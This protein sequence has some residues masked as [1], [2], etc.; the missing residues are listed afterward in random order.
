MPGG[1][2]PQQRE[3]RINRFKREAQAAGT[4]NHPNI[5]TVYELGQEGDRLFMA[6]EYL[7]G[8]NLRNEI[9][10]KGFLPV[11]Q[12]VRIAK[13]ILKGLDFAHERGVIHRDIKPDNIQLLSNGAVKITDFGIARLTFQP[14]LT[15]DG[16]VF[17]TP[18]YMSPEQVVGREIDS[19]SDLF[20][21]AIVLYEMLGG[22]KPF[23]GSS[24]METTA[25]IMNK[26]PERLGQL[27]NA[28]WGVI[29]KTL[30]KTPQMRYAS[31][32]KMIDAINT[33][34]ALPNAVGPQQPASQFPTYGNQAPSYPA[35][36][37]SYNPYAPPVQQAPPPVQYPYNPYTPGPSQA[38]SYP[39]QGS[40]LPVYYPPPPR[41]P[42]FKPETRLVMGK[43]TLTVLIVGALFAVVW[44]A[45]QAVAQ[46]WQSKNAGS[47]KPVGVA[48]AQ[49]TT[50]AE[51]YA[52]EADQARQNV[53]R[54][55]Q[56]ER[57]NAAEAERLLREGTQLDP[58]NVE[59][60]D[61]LGKLYASKAAAVPDAED[62]ASLWQQAGES[63]KTASTIAPLQRQDALKEQSAEA[64]LRAAQM[65]GRGQQARMLL[66]DARQMA[67]PGS[68]IALQVKSVLAEL[69]GG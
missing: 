57:S 33:A 20:S 66:Y 9:D 25:Q 51:Q 2:T 34:V 19:R 23:Q 28:L 37:P 14:N 69:S 16:Q 64:Y 30:D 59:A 41:P 61:Q 42:M 49:P 32:T 38:P 58:G 11:D 60:Y 67:P 40:P 5:M 6:M 8:H 53:S 52:I 50:K 54:A 44:V 43:V 35:P 56:L 10:T 21:V 29:E 3:E 27:D 48:T 39:Q 17:G 22:K 26:A 47:S 55:A 13:E 62:A 15:V 1:S 68:N 31:A 7:D 45:T 65:L 18:S 4:L 46:A 12:A 24:V 36:L 63:W